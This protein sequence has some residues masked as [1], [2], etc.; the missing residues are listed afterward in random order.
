L[1]KNSNQFTLLFAVAMCVI[2]A[3]ALAATF[4]GL[5][6][7][8]DKNKLFDKNRNVLI[9]VGLYDPEREAKS[10]ADLEKLFAD[11]VKAQVLKFTKDDVRVP[12][13]RKGREMEEEVRRV[14]LVE[15]TDNRIEDLPRLRRELRQ[16]RDKDHEFGSIY[17]A[18]TPNGTVYC[19]PISGAGLWSILHGFLALKDDLNTVVGIT[20]YQHGE[21]P[22]LGGE[23]E[24]EW[25]QQDW[26]GKKIL[27]DG[28]LVSVTVL[29]GRGHP[30]RGPHEV[31]GISGATITCNGV[32][33]F[34]REDLE[35][36]EP[37]FKKLRKS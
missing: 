12:V 13:K 37:Y 14:V 4:H 24:K 36:Y 35:R 23:V 6:A 2:L 28:R 34:L 21:T 18:D 9:A 3:T 15:K 22:G 29:R 33:R 20:F 25:W 31:D 5:K 32:T 19:I 16:Q 1:D 11:K 26:K 30:E 10:Q 27:A 17:L 8:M 7:S